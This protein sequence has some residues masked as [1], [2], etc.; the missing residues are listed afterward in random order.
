MSEELKSMRISGRISEEQYIFVDAFKGKS[1]NDK[2]SNL[3]Q[4]YLEY[5]SKHAQMER[6]IEHLTETK[7]QLLKEIDALKMDKQKISDAFQM[8]D[9]M[10]EDTKRDLSVDRI[11]R[12]IRHSGY[13]PT[14]QLITDIRQLDQLTGKENT[15]KDIKEGHKAQSYSS[16]QP[17]VQKLVD[18]VYG[19]LHQQALEQIH[20]ILP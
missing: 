13:R 11:Q 3:L 6:E 19:A 15:L 18:K 12:M 1:F 9:R 20:G 4:F 5:P 2:L 10:M 8:F 16:D 14:Q 7:L 17:E